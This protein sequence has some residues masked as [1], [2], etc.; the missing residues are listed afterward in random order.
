[1]NVNAALRLL[2]AGALS[3]LLLSTHAAVIEVTAGGKVSEPTYMFSDASG[4]A[5]ATLVGNSTALSASA[6]LVTGNGNSVDELATAMASLQ[7]IIA[8][9]NATVAQL[10][11]R[12]ELAEAAIS[13]LQTALAAKLDSSDASSYITSASAAAIYASETEL[14]NVLA[15]QHLS[16]RCHFANSKHLCSS[17]NFCSNQGS[18]TFLNC[19]KLCAM[20]TNCRSFDYSGSTCML[21]N[22]PNKP[23]DR[24]SSPD[25]GGT[26]YLMNLFYDR[27]EQIHPCAVC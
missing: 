18:Q 10:D 4:N 25:S 24:G 21:V 2:Q 8:Q 9:L 7:A 12:L 26:C 6:D 11:A 5:L 1:M 15:R 3:F 19:A 16:G 23:N 14:F 22:H 17:Y 13:T 20:T 27:S